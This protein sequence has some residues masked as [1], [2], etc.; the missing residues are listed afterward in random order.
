[1][2]N[3][4]CFL[5]QK[6]NP[7]ALELKKKYSCFV[8]PWFCHCH[9]W[10]V[11][12]VTLQVHQIFAGLFSRE[13]VCDG[14][15]VRCVSSTKAF[16]EVCHERTDKVIHQDICRVLF[17]IPCLKFTHRGIWP[18]HPYLVWRSRSCRLCLLAGMSS[19]L[20]EVSSLERC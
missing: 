20:S 13:P 1:M 16:S 14:C 9:T 6:S 5:F 7:F 19:C 8:V 4:V 11:K 10:S 12:P 3:K 18:P 2:E 15:M 17:L